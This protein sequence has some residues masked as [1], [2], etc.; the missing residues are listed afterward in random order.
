MPMWV[1]SAAAA[2]PG[3]GS[4]QVLLGSSLALTG[5]LG[6][7]GSAHVAGVQAALKTVNAN[8]GIAGREIKLQVLDDAYLPA[9]TAD[10]VKRLL[11]GEQPVF[12]LMSSMGTANTAAALPLVEQAGV[13]LVGPVTGAVSLR[14]PGLRQVFHVRA[15]Y[16][17]ETTR[18]MQ[19][20]T[21]WGLRSI[22]IVYLDN[23]FGKE[24]LQDA[25][26]T[27][28]ASG[29]SV[30]GAF[31]LAVD[32]S[33]GEALARQVLDARPAALFLATTGT[34]NTRFL[35][36]LRQLSSALP[37]AG[38]SVSVTSSELPKLGKA[39]QGLALTQV[40]PDANSARTVM[41]RSFQAAMRAAGHEQVIGGSS[42]EGWI[43]AQVMLEG[44]R[45]A[46]PDLRRD[47]LRAAL[48]GLRRLDLGDFSLGYG[49]QGPFVASQYIDLAVM[50]ANGK[51]LT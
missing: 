16:R 19:Q 27:I 48:A 29:A 50:G 24:V 25:Q 43:N 5:V 21:S 12:A 38:L 39:L 8:G 23:P 31:A 15:S 46:G 44:L 49:T 47:K 14:Q 18:L 10:N 17:D 22:A 7:S 33:N 41:V 6:E 11:G 40:L 20:L 32:G 2:E 28:T 13:P 37:V 45:R 36:P 9:R 42:L 4:N 35:Q 1:G 51:R 3:V 34:A 30:A 26:A